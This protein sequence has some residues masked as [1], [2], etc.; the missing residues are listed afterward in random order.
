M[1]AAALALFFIPFASLAQTQSNTPKK[2]TTDCPTFTNQPKM[3][4]AAS[5]EALRH[6]RKPVKAGEE[7]PK[8]QKS[9][10]PAF[11]SGDKV[12]EP[13]KTVPAEKPVEKAVTPEEKPKKE[14][15]A[16]AKTESSAAVAEQKAPKKKKTV[17]NSG[18]VRGTK[19]NAEDCPQF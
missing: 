18:K 9:H 14:K 16:P 15:A 10:T 17:L 5:Y 8:V 6:T 11:S 12:L 4:K 13:K 2:S 1:K 7:K 19:R 3:N